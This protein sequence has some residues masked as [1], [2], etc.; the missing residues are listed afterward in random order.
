MTRTLSKIRSA[1]STDSPYRQPECLTKPKCAKFIQVPLSSYQYKYRAG[2]V[3]TDKLI[4]LYV[5][6]TI[7]VLGSKLQKLV[8]I[9]SS[10]AFNAATRAAI[11]S[12]ATVTFTG[13]GPLQGIQIR[14]PLGLPYPTLPLD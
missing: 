10:T 12:T 11:N 6:I 2:T 5:L 3:S 7:I 1:A 9:C 8:D 14:S 4:E 13:F